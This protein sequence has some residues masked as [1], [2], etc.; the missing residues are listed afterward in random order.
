[1]TADSAISRVALKQ[2]TPDVSAAMGGLHR[3]AVAAAKAAGVE[4]ELLELVRIRASQ[5]NGCAFCLDMH[6]K[7][8]RAKGETEQRLYALDAWQETPFYTERE[9]AALA[10]TEAVTL[11]ADGR[12]PDA[13]YQEAASV[14]KEDELAAVL[15]AAIVI[16]A[17]NR[18][19]ISTRMAVGGYQPAPSA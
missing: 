17:Y 8:A 9:R 5:L 10:L 19:A 12:V 14:F 13:V 6:T 18:I 4:P 2:L 1:M 3:E 16:N 7:D 15:W 11:V